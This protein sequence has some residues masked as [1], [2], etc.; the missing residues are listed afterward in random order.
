MSTA[1]AR[2]VWTSTAARQAASE[3]ARE[4]AHAALLA[5][6]DAYAARLVA[7]DGPDAR[8]GVKA[9][10]TDGRHR[11]VGDARRVAWAVLSPH[12]EGCEWWLIEG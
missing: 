12:S 6:V 4:A 3:A 7:D 9:D 5:R 2:L 10:D 8:Y 11:F 1:T